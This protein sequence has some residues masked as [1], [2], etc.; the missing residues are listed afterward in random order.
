MKRL[1]DWEVTFTFRPLLF[2]RRTFMAGAL[3]FACLAPIHHVGTASDRLEPTVAQRSH[4][5]AVAAV[6][7]V[8]GSRMAY[9]DAGR[10]SRLVRTIVDESL[11]C[12][13]DPLFILAVGDVE[14]RLDHEAVSPTGARGLY[15]VMPRTWDAEVKRRGLG[16]M[17]KFNVV[18]NAKVGI[19]YLC[20][21]GQTFKRP[22]S[23]LL[24]Y[25]QG[26]GGASAIIARRAEP[27]AEAASY[28]AKVW[29]S[30]R[31]FL[32]SFWLPDSAKAM[33]T[34][35]KSPELTVYTPLLGYSSDGHGPD[36]QPPKKVKHVKH[37]AKHVKP[38]PK[39]KAFPL[40]ARPE[41]QNRPTW[42]ARALELP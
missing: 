17:E 23:L 9:L 18:H 42:A 10:R 11:A 22:D 35:Y 14:S 36:P 2:L 6:D 12:G 38:V 16:H 29:K 25:N 21:L 15:Q 4:E 37:R 39:A 30:Y 5:N 28:A 3:A 7:R 13:F 40:V 32:S 24:A 20:Y 41:A 26:P 31:A 1:I 33:R 19:G 27:S 8:I 34:L